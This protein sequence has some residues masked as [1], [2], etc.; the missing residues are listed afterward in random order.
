MPV[1]QSQFC[2]CILKIPVSLEANFQASCKDLSSTGSHSLLQLLLA[3]YSEQ[4]QLPLPEPRAAASDHPG[5][6]P[7][8]IPS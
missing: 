4:L 8:T 3:S 1:S 6:S 7:G 2:I 5:P